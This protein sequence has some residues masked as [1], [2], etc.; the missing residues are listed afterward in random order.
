MQHISE[1]LRVMQD[2]RNLNQTRVM[3]EYNAGFQAVAAGLQ[4]SPGTWEVCL[5]VRSTVT[6]CPF[7][8]HVAFDD[9]CLMYY[10]NSVCQLGF[11]HAARYI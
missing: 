4:E 8:M 3:L 9:S 5:Q 11:Y 2:V 7:G 10:I 1:V 6:Q